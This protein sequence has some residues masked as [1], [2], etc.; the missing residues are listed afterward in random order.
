MPTSAVHADNGQHSVTVL[1]G[2]TTRD[3]DVEIGAIGAAWTEITVGL[4]AGSVVVLADLDEPLPGT[5]T[6]S[7]GSTQIGFPGGGQLPGGGRF[8][9]GG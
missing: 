9:G 6:D 1:D 4:D 2:T 5:A 8:P 3:V 7:S